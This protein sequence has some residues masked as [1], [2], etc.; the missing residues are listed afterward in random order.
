MSGEEKYIAIGR[1]LENAVDSQMFGKPCFKVKG[2]AFVSYFDN[3][4][5]FKLGGEAHRDALSL[6]GA[7]LFDPAKKG[8]P[9]KEWVQLPESYSDQW[10]DFARSAIEYVD[11]LNS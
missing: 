11:N 3:C 10:A 6:D 1:S 7:M 8:R 4:M 9:M 5:V 2:K